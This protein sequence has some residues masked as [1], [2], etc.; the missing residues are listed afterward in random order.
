MVQDIDHSTQSY[1][2]LKLN[3]ADFATTDDN[4][5]GMVSRLWQEA[6]AHPYEAGL[7]AAA[8]IASAG[9][10]IYALSKGDLMPSCFKGAADVLLVEDTPGLGN[11]F[12]EAIEQNGHKVTWVTGI[13][14]LDPLTAFTPDGGEMAL[15]R[16]YKIAFLDGDLGANR[17]TGPEI[18]G[19]LAKKTRVIG[20]STVEDFNVAMRQNSL[21]PDGTA[22]AIT[23]NKGV[24]F[25][26]LVGNRLDMQAALKTP[27]AVQASLDA[28]KAT[29]RAPEN[30]ALKKEA[31]ARLTKF[32]LA[33]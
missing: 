19:T 24:V 25:A 11:A 26:S 3:K 15:T 33:K 9:V 16:P 8:V 32:L 5:Q 6:Y 1:P 13:K 31:D 28:L 7:G 27:E 22:A 10:G 4:K 30:L 21:N 12:K 17:L 20:T 14:T 29:L 23:G 2:E 18:V